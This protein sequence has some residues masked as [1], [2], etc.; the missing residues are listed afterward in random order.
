MG[1]DQAGMMGNLKVFDGHLNPAQI[2]K[3]ILDLAKNGNAGHIGCSLCLVEL[4]TVLYTHFIRLNWEHLND[5]RRDIL[6]LSKGHGVMALYACFKE[7][8]WVSEAEFKNYLSPTNYLKGLSSVH[9]EGIEVSG[10]SLG[11]GITTA[12]GMAKASKILEDG[13]NVFCII[14]DGESNEGSVWE[15]LMFAAHHQLDN[16]IVLV[17]HNNYQAMGKT[18]SIIHGSILKKFTSFGFDSIEIDGHNESEIK[19][20]ISELMNN[21]SYRPKAVVANTI[22]G[23]GVSFMENN[24]IWH[25]QRM[26]E[27]D[28]AMAVR[29]VINER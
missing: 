2:R 4:L 13:S 29:D 15:S 7:F 5:P 27:N 26:T 12:V 21:K 10:G 23:K 11:Q 18:E 16:L 17:D 8:G 14:G 9:V 24:N 19:R 3:N 1:L 20:A 28:Y 6:A 25:Y 22:K